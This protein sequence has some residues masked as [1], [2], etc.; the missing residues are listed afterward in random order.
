MTNPTRAFKRQDDE[1]DRLRAE[2]EMLRDALVMARECIAYC[3]RA[4]P[5]IQKG[6]GVPVEVLIDAAL[7]KVRT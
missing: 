3:R 4:H 6:D 7:A 2:V 5:D 1:I